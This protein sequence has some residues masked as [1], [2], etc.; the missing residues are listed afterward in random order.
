[1]H[2]R[3]SG[4][5]TN[6]NPLGNVVMIG[7]KYRCDVIPL[8]STVNQIACKTG[9]A[10]YGSETRPWD[11]GRTA[12]PDGWTDLMDVKITVD[13]ARNSTC[14]STASHG[15]A[16]MYTTSWLRKF[17]SSRKQNFAVPVA[18]HSSAGIIRPRP[19]LTT[20]LEFGAIRSLASQPSSFRHPC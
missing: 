20:R 16:F 18:S 17:F 5:S 12:L 1:M 15:C 11:S 6:M 3:G 2:I 10:I 9:S 14:Q 8:H 19:A 7:G 13:G 4:F